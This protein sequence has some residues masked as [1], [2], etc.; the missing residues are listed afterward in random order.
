VQIANNTIAEIKGGKVESTD[1]DVALKAESASKVKMTNMIAEVS[2]LQVS[3]GS[4]IYEN[5]SETLAQIRDATVNAHSIGV[6]SKSKSHATIDTTHIA[7]AIGSVVN[8]DLVEANDT[9]KTVSLITGN[10]NID[11]KDKLTLHSTVDTD[12]QSLKLSVPIAGASLV[13]VMK[14][15]AAANTI[16]RAII[17]NV[18]GTISVSGN[19]KVF[20]L[21]GRLVYEGIG[22]AFRPQS[23]T[24]Y[25]IKSAEGTKKVIK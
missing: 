25:I 2:G 17:E 16:S 5:S 8:V 14:N 20:T 11:A 6:N 21:D 19:V 9:N 13:S 15:D 12:L 10:T 24:A 3:G 23:K 7:G 1:G 18:N 22:S 4:D